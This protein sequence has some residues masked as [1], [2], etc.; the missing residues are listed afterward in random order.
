MCKTRDEHSSRITAY[1]FGMP[2]FPIQK[3]QMSQRDSIKWFEFQLIFYQTVV[4]LSRV[5][6][7]VSLDLWSVGLSTCMY[8]QMIYA[9]VWFLGH[10][11]HSGDL[12][13]LGFMCCSLIILHFKLLENHETNCYH[14]W[15]KIVNL[16]PYHEGGLK[17]R[18]QMQKRQNFLNFSSLLPNMWEKLNVWLFKQ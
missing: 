16:W 3:W 7:S 1:C 11:N 12:L 2:S 6:F 9:G 5:F 8:N 14:F 4:F 17:N 13:Q 10:L 15:F 18:A